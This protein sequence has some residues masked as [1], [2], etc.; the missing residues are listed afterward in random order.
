MLSILKP[1]ETPNTNDVLCGRGGK[2]NKYIGNRQF[3]AIVDTH[4]K[5]YKAATK[6]EKALI[7]REIIDEIGVMRPPGR[8][9]KKTSD[10]GSFWYEETKENALKK[11]SQALR[12]GVH[13]KHILDRKETS[14]KK[15]STPPNGSL[16][17]AHPSTI[18]HSDNKA[19]KESL[20]M[21]ER[22]AAQTRNGSLKSEDEY[23]PQVVPRHLPQPYEASRRDS[24]SMG[25][26]QKIL[27]DT[28]NQHIQR[29][30]TLEQV[31]RICDV[32]VGNDRQHRLSMTFP[33]ISSQFG[34]RLHSLAFNSI[35]DV[36]VATGNE[37]F[38]DPFVK[39]NV[40]KDV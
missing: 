28:S 19:V 18:D 32:N 16:K 36:N 13:G 3:R 11:T 37:P 7:A 5:R 14:K 12:E 34:N 10:S 2:I 15:S 20:L 30:S 33:R 1:V 8:F 29:L 4:K 40:S 39:P 31:S 23:V 35:G 21:I 26:L 17:V 24:L 6:K 9:L 25:D 22:L 27:G 38:R